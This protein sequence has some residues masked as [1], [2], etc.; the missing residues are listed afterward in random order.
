MPLL[1]HDRAS[2]RVV[3]LDTSHLAGWF[4]DRASDRADE[5][6]RA[7]AFE[8]RLERGGWLPLLTWHHFEELLQ[9][10]NALVVKRRIRALHSLKRLAWIGSLRSGG[11]GAVTDIMAAEALAACRFPKADLK[12]IVMNAR[13]ILLHTGSGQD[14]LGDNALKWLAFQ[15]LVHEREGRTREIVAINQSNFAG[16]GQTKISTLLQGQRV[17]DGAEIDARL[18]TLSQRLAGDIATRGDRRI[19]NPSKPADQLMAEA[20]AM[21]AETPGSASDLV[22][23]TLFNQGIDP[24]DIGPDTTLDDLTALIVYRLQLKI[25]SENLSLPWPIVKANVPMDRAPSYLI[26]QAL[27]A[28]AQ[29]LPEHKGSEL[30]DNYLLR[31]G[32]YADL[33][34]VDKRTLENVKRARRKEPRLEGLLGEVARAAT[35][36]DILADV[37][38][39]AG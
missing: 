35:Y 37:G 28:N 23:G 10:R 29:V 4:A 1:S 14:L 24:A 13:Q 9:H 33:A 18:A 26:G 21:A 19:D 6:R 3:L 15:P 30:N 39:K 31:A 2:P 27:D 17:T 8:A 34:F 7:A 11:L 32:A 36:Q 25:V 38:A 20:A 16:I 12:T 22:L 5:R